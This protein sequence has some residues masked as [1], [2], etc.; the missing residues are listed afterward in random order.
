M[1]KS[2]ESRTGY[3]NVF[4]LRTDHIGPIYHA[5]ITPEVGKGQ[6][7]VPKSYSRSARES[8]A[9]LAYFE[10][11]YLGEL[12]QKKSYQHRRTA[13]VRCPSRILPSILSPCGCVLF[14]GDPKGQGG[15]GAGEDG[16]QG[17]QGGGSGAA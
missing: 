4:L 3:K 1:T 13:E 17:G 6:R 11:G 5:K 15:G 9:R 14:V 2:S 16:A 10:S 12:Q 7:N 8:A